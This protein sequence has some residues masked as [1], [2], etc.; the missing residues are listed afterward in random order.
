MENQRK[1]M[2]STKEESLNPMPAHHERQHWLVS[3][4]HAHLVSD[5]YDLTTKQVHDIL[6]SFLQSLMPP[7]PP[8]PPAPLRP[9]KVE[10]KHV[11]L[12]P[13]HPH[14]TL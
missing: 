14:L 9:T 1:S 12:P 2:K 4:L 10:Y 7:A 6:E 5:D 11:P 8:R 13:L 3:I